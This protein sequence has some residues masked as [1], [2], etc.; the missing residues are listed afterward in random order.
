MIGCFAQGAIP[1]LS[2]P[3]LLPK[4]A[5][6]TEIVVSRDI[7]KLPVEIRVYLPGDPEDAPFISTEVTPGE[8]VIASAD[9]VEDR[10]TPYPGGKVYRTVNITLSSPVTIPHEGLIQVRAFRGD[11][12]YPLG[13][14]AVRAV[15]QA[16]D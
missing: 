2:F 13:S 6:F 7:E 10:Q 5:I 12:Y 3:T 4:L 14:T 16:E 11:R 8:N 1:V 9:D 15:A